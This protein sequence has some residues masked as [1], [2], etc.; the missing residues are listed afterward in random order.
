MSNQNDQLALIVGF[1]AAGKSASFRN[2][3]NQHNWYYLGCE[4]G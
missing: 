2:I 1:S 3:T 4:A